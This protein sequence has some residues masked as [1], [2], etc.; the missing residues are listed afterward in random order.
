MPKSGE[1]D[2]QV[3]PRLAVASI[4]TIASGQV[5][6]ETCDTIAGYDARCPQSIGH[7]RDVGAQLVPGNLPP[8]AAFVARND[9][10]AAA[11]AAQQVFGEVQPGACE[12]GG[13]GHA[14][15]VAQHGSGT[16]IGDHPREVED[17]IPEGS[18]LIHRPLP[19]RRVIAA[20]RT[21]V[22]GER[23]ESRQ[24][25]GGDAIGRRNPVGCV[26]VHAPNASRW[27]LCAPWPMQRVPRRLSSGSS[28][29][30]PSSSVRHRASRSSTGRQLQSR[31]VAATGPVR[32]ASR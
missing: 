26:V 2:D 5:R 27:S 19:Q 7:A 14:V 30:G 17:R 13:A 10:R 8:P 6:H 29:S 15:A 20:R 9:G 12:P 4:A 25:R 21:A 31:S 1:H 22:T 24:L 32:R 11:G 28:R 16:A 23:V 3:A 18:R